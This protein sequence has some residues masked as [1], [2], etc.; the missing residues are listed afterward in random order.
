MFRIQFNPRLATWQVQLLVFGFWWRTIQTER[1][2][3]LGD[4]KDFCAHTGLS[5]L[6]REQLPFHQFQAVQQELDLNGNQ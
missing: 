6:Y 2:A 3:R 5:H 4:A 1:F